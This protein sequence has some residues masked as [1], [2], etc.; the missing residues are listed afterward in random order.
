MSTKPMVFIS[1]SWD[2][3]EHN[4][5][6]RKLHSI[7]CANGVE[8]LIDKYE[9]FLGSNLENYMK[10]GLNESKYV[11]CIC[12]GEYLKKTNDPMT[13]VGKEIDI[14]KVS[15][16]T[17]FIIPIIK[18]NQEKTLPNFLSGRWYS[19]FSDVI[20]N[21]QDKNGIE[22]IRELLEHVFNVDDS[23]K[24]QGGSNPFEAI[25]GNE[26]I[27]NTKINRSMY[28]NPELTGTVEFD[29]SNNDKKYTFGTG[30]FSFTTQWSKASDTSIHAYNDSSNISH[31]S[32]I[33]DLVELPEE[34]PDVKEL[35][36]TSRTRTPKRGDGIVWL[37][38][39]GHFAITI[40]RD[41]MDDTR[42]DKIDW[43]KFDYRVYLTERN[44]NLE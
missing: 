25:L 26:I 4:N 27:V 28:I 32:I 15:D 33:K 39:N 16:K 40:V 22:K 30:E 31:I 37:N 1:Y 11:L 21:G 35:D 34:L 3:D 10:Q 9:V 14:I 42:G 17:D 41:I 38:T 36:F 29:Y 13:G 43:L 19:D 24:S 2:S 12:S 44:I 20:L 23:L 8:A 7:L 18:N 5:W 6:V